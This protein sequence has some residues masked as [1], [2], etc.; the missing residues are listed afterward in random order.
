MKWF[1]CFNFSFMI[2]LNIYS[3][4][5]KQPLQNFADL[6]DCINGQS[7]SIW[8]F[9]GDKNLYNSMFDIFAENVRHLFEYIYH[10]CIWPQ[11]TNNCLWHVL[12]TGQIWEKLRTFT[13]YANKD[14]WMC[15]G[16]TGP[17]QMGP[18]PHNMGL[19][20]KRWM[21]WDRAH[22]FIYWTI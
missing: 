1:Q 19:V 7:W 2:N 15:S 22:N 14:M 13:R 5:F 16:S 12:Q 3:S 21:F 9:F 6:Q 17:I 20:P 8:S 4:K 10:L 11:R 18:V